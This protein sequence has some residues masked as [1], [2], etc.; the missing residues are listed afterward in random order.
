MPREEK[1]TV[2]ENSSLRIDKYLSKEFT[3]I[4]RAFAQKLIIDGLVKVNN[5]IVKQNYKVNF[6]DT[7]DITIPEAEELQMKAEDIALEIAYE[8]DDLIVVNKPQ[9]MVVHPAPGNYSG[10]LVNALLS[11]CRGNLSEINGIIR[12]GIV[13]RID[14]DTSGLLLIAKNNNAHNSL[15]KQ[16]KDHTVKRVYI[17]IV[18]GNVKNVKGTINLP[19]GRHPINRKKMC[20]TE[21][22]SRNAVTHFELVESFNNYSLLECRLETGRTHQIRVHLSYIGHPVLG[23]PSYSQNKNYKLGLNGQALH[24]KII[25]FNHPTTNTYMEFEAKL[26]EY[27][28]KTLDRL[29]L[30]N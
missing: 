29:R 22:N 24:A 10:T 20:V 7:V 16:I 13:H 18:H 25:G 8:D 1:I 28:T 15:A 9:G 4:S 19:I 21:R 14:K 23:D 2:D 11:H 12:P 30:E 3:D 27:F 6:N 5:K 17:T 26:P